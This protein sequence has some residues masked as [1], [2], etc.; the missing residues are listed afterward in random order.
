MLLQNL[1]IMRICDFRCVFVM[2]NTKLFKTSC[3]A[4]MIYDMYIMILQLLFSGS[5][6]PRLLVGYHLSVLII[7]FTILLKTT[8]WYQL[9]SISCMVFVSLY[10]FVR[11]G[12]DY[13]VVWK[14]YQAE[15]VILKQQLSQQQ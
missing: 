11:L 4:K 6:F 3:N 12:R 10:A 14:M 1:E 8:D 2:L 15:E 7:C 9:I 13:L 5:A